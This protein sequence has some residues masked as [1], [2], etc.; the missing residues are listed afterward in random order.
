MNVSPERRLILCLFHI[1]NNKAN[2]EAQLARHAKLETQ[3][4]PGNSASPATAER[5]SFF[6]GPVKKLQQIMGV[7][8]EHSGISRLVR[9]MIAISAAFLIFSAFGPMYDLTE[10]Y[11]GYEDVGFID[12]IGQGTDSILADIMTEDGFL[13][14][15]ALNSTEGDR[16]TAN[17]I[18]AYEVEPGDTLSSVA[19]RFGIKK[20]T[21]VMEND[22]WNVNSLRTGMTLKILPVDG[23]SHVVKKGDTVDKIAKK[24]EVEAED[25]IRQN[26]LEE[27]AVLL[28]DSALIIPGGKKTVAPPVVNYGGSAPANPSAYS[29]VGSGGGRLIWPTLGSAKLTQGFHAGHY[30]I[31]IG[32]R[33]KGP[34]FAAAAGKV[35]EASYGWN[36]GY[37]NVVII[38]HGNGMQTLYAHNEKLYVTEGQYVDQ[39]QTVS[40]MGR[41]GRVYGPTGIHVHFEVRINGVK[42][43]P[44]NFF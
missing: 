34:I 7:G 20:E 26:Q 6:A 3:I 25:I 16:S 9:K 2:I 36:G 29:Y 12:F 13:L 39:G 28:A 1:N 21:I 43:N 40:W 19:Q 5:K 37:G 23:I 30:A 17:E 8:C 38:D 18:F 10:G 44:M 15:P 24:Y 33:N 11:I 27:D 22:L 42:Y 14:K 35:V 31:D 4:A 32:N 41:S